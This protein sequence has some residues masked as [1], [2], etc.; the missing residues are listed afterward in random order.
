M[1]GFLT[2]KVLTQ[3]LNILNSNIF[4]DSSQICASCLTLVAWSLRQWGHK[5]LPTPRII[6][7]SSKDL[8][9]L[10]EFCI[11]TTHPF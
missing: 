9:A 5:A 7:A 2:D 10:M 3:F 1:G 11:I 8:G 6:R 4:M